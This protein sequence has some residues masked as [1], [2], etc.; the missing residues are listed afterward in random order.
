MVNV[1]R[2]TV[3]NLG[4]SFGSVWDEKSNSPV[5][6]KNG[7]PGGMPESERRNMKAAERTSTEPSLSYKQSACQKLDYYLSMS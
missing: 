7:H 3:I 4:N 5:S 1:V 6:E 2:P